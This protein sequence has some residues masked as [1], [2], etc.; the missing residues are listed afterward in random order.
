MNNM[1]IACQT[2]QD[3]LNKVMLETECQYPITWVDSEY[4]IDP[5]K[6]R[7]KLQ[8]EIDQV[9]QIENI[10]LVY[11]S[12]GN[13]LVG[14][15]ASTANL[16]IPR[17]DDCISMVLSQRGQEFQRHKQTYFFTK[18]WMD[19]SKSLIKEYSHTLERYGPKRAKRIFDQMLKHYRHLML[20]DTGAYILEDIQEQVTELAQN[21]DLE[22]VVAKG[23]LWW[24][25]Q[26]L[27]GPYDENFCVISKGESVQMKHFGDASRRSAH[28]II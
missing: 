28:Q 2:L 7:N 3:E 15:Q 12:C 18:G 22:L 16:I 27:E 24:L 9:T 20:I 11:G 8:E 26:L 4:H 13:G 14:L 25:R 21:L 6:L 17:T 10:F 23:E 1:I 19:G 5:D